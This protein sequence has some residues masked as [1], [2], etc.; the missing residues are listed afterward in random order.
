MH[1]GA[2]PRVKGIIPKTRA[3]LFKRALE[4]ISNRDDVV[5]VNGP[6]RGVTADEKWFNIG[7]ARRLTVADGVLYGYRSVGLLVVCY[8][9]EDKFSIK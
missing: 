2:T 7:A 6:I 3:F 8:Q 1:H 5:R 9:W 4:D